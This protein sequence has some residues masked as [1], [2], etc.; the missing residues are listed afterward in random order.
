MK[1][2]Y[3]IQHSFG[4]LL[5]HITIHNYFSK[6]HINRMIMRLFGTNIMAGIDLFR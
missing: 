6:E 2:E 1:D 5:N 4:Y 3:S